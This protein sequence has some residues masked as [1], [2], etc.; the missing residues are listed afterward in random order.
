MT[1]TV[2]LKVRMSCQGCS[3][4][5]RRKLEKLQGVASYDIDMDK[6]KV[7]VIGD[8]DPQE[9]FEHISRTGKET[10]FWVEPQEAAVEP[11]P[12]TEEAVSVASVEPEESKLITEEAVAV[13]S[14][15]P[16]SKPAAEAVAS[17]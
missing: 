11:E 13:A 1:Q 15:K 5:V 14:V 6:Q 8:V 10:S 12:T 2:E 16:E 4:A 7:T 9:V 3:G 17:A